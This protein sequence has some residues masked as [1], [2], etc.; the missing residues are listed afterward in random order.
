M[1]CYSS[2]FNQ[3]KKSVESHRL[4]VET[5]SEHAPSVRTSEVWFRQFKSDDFVVKKRG[6]QTCENDRLQELLDD[7]TT[8]TQRQLAEALRVT[9]NNRQA[10]AR[11][12]EDQ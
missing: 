6:T 1:H 3:K 12:G 10:F 5:Y 11:D 4:L 2:S 9:K 8:K 7:D